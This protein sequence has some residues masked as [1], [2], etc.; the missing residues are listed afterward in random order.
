MSWL[1]TVCAMI[2]EACLSSLRCLSHLPTM[3]D[4][5]HYQFNYEDFE[6]NLSMR[7]SWVSRHLMGLA[8]LP[9]PLD[10][11]IA[12]CNFLENGHML[13]WPSRSKKILDGY[14]GGFIRRQSRRYDPS[15]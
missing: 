5:P 10:A 15:S 8:P 12:C 14:Q 3:S 4:H 13:Y 6:Q 7:N 2:R 1:C 11:L 9:L